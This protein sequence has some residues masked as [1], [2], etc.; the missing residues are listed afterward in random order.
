MGK[1]RT[2]SH[3]ALVYRNIV[4]LLAILLPVVVSAQ[5]FQPVNDDPFGV[6]VA[7]NPDSVK[8]QRISEITSNFQYKPDGKIIQDKGLQEHF[9]FDKEGRVVFYWRTRVKG[10]EPKAV[11]H[12]PVY[13][14]GR[15]VKDGWT[16]YKYTYSYDT[17]FIYSYYDSLSRLSIRRMC[18]G[19]YYHAWYY[20]YDEDG[21]IT[22]QIHCRE[23][24][25]GSSHRDF[26]LGAQTEISREDFRY[27]K[28]S[29][30]SIKKLSVNDEGKSYK[31]TMMY[32]DEK[33]RVVETRE[34]FMAG[35]IRI[36]CGYEYDSLG[37]FLSCTYSSNAG[38]P[39][40]ELTQ[41]KYDSLGRIESIRR[42]RNAVLKD[43]FSYLY[44]GN[45]K[46]SYAYI[47]RRHIDQGIDIVKMQ[48]VNY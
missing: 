11:E 32:L 25:L 42:F 20:T 19:V 48:V 45:A 5:L 47:N 4:A 33:G 38:D 35:G 44:E 13:R 15:K 6:P 37:R 23:T 16:E 9:H 29:S 39:V 31:E 46:V 41:Y 43:E 12:G 30:R 40:N 7:F 8:A 18:E 1:Y 22:T 34:A 26:R 24:N 10:M 2:G 21:L 3:S 28:Y 17:L 36:T 27:E 14:K